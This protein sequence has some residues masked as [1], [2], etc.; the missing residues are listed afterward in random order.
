MYPAPHGVICA[1]LLPYVMETNV[2][3]VKNRAE[4]SPFLARYA[5]VAQILT[6]NPGATPADGVDWV[7]TLCRELEIPGLSEY[8]VKKM[9]FPTIIA[10]TQKSS[11]MKGN[12]IKLTD[13]ELVYTLDQA[14]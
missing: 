6:G 11:S 1:R 5:D 10:K 2:R 14:I 7:Q 8:G 12:P 4:D 13:D 9:D 3:A